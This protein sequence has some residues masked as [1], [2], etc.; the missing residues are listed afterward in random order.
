MSP[1]LSESES[2]SVEEDEEAVIEA[3]VVTERLES[4][5]KAEGQ[6]TDMGEQHHG[7]VPNGYERRTDPGTGEVYFVNVFTGGKVFF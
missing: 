2:R 5:L 4:S 7:A 3:V 1:G 6:T